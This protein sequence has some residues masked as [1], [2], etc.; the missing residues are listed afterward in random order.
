MAAGFT[1]RTIYAKE[2]TVFSTVWPSLAVNNGSVL[3]PLVAEDVKRVAEYETFE[4][5][6]ESYPP[7]LLTERV[8]GSFS[9]E[10]RYSGI[11]F[12]LAAAMGFQKPPVPETIDTGVYRHIY[13][14][15][16]TIHASP[17]TF[18]EGWKFGQGLVFG[19]RKT[20]RGTYSSQ[21]GFTMWQGLSC[22]LNDFT[23][24][25]ES[26]QAATITCG[27]LGYNMTALASPG[28]LDGL[29]VASGPLLHQECAVLIR[30]E[31]SDT[32]SE[33]GE[34]LEFSVGFSNSLSKIYG[35][36]DGDH[37][38]EPKK[39]EESIVTG[40]LTLPH[41]NA[42]H[43]LLNSWFESRTRLTICVIYVGEDINDDF[44][45]SMKIWLPRV[46]LVSNEANI[47][48]PG[49][50]SQSYSFHAMNQ[51]SAVIDGMPDNV[52]T[53]PMLIEL[54]NTESAHPLL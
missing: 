21:K 39:E 48:G 15:D 10:A 6:T 34:V 19:Q 9:I 49:Q 7:L 51:N 20:R 35:T 42:T 22:M 17:W 23:F 36:L 43:G 18:G 45:F 25:S 30:E 26:S 5:V 54:V 37:I 40:Q 2:A 24:S 8:E 33:V 38:L 52:K 32:F 13:E 46:T 31:T 53:G 4:G 12:L 14:I 29:P 27:L 50:I 47:E 16:R 28:P 44:P 41:Y 11:E 1:T 3:L